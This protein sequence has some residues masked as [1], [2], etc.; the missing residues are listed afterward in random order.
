ME[1]LKIPMS[2]VTKFE[3]TIEEQ[4]RFYIAMAL[5][6]YDFFRSPDY[7]EKKL[8]K[9]IASDLRLYLSH[10]IKELG[11][12]NNDRTLYRKKLFIENHYKQVKNILKREGIP[13]NKSNKTLSEADDVL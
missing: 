1:E 4:K 6:Q 13:L 2:T 3:L 12:N 5:I 11:E 8:L 9:V 7:N 10:T